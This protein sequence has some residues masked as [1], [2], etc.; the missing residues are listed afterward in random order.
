M[1]YANYSFR[2]VRTKSREINIVLNQCIGYRSSD[3]FFRRKNATRHKWDS[4]N[5]VKKTFF[6]KIYNFHLICRQR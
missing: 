6:K 2:I 1:H 4:E 3:D 5:F